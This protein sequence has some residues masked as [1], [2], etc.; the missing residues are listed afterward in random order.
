MLQSINALHKLTGFDRETVMRRLK[1][2]HFELAGDGPT[3]AKQF[4][5]TVALPILYGIDPENPGEKITAAEAARRLTLARERQ[6]N[7][8]TEVTSGERLHRDDVQEVFDE[9]HGDIAA[10]IKSK[11]DALGNEAVTDIFGKLREAAKKLCLTQS[12]TG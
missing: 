4:E 7:V 8:Q 11:A 6:V 10:I 3:A 12:Q 5:S 2:L 1:D 9:M